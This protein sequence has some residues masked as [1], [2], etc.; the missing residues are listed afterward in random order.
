[1]KISDEGAHRIYELSKMVYHSNLSAK[2][3]I[4]F[5]LAE[6]LMAKSSAQ[7]YLNIFKCLMNGVAH[8]RA[9]NAYSTEYFLESIYDD[10]GKDFFL[11]ALQSTA[12][13]VI[14]YNSLNHGRRTSISKIIDRLTKKYELDIELLTVYPDEI[15]GE[16]FPEGMSKQVLINLFERNK[17]ARSACIEEHGLSCC[18][19][20]FNF[21][22]AYGEIGI[23]FIHVHH[24]VNISDI[25]HSYQVDPKRDLIPVCPNC[26]AMLH[27]SKP[28]HTIQ[29]LKAH[30]TNYLNGYEKLG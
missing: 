2:K 18:V 30:L 17:N 15:D 4:E 11:K 3:A 26:H 9:I 8:K 1:M 28:A 21:E 10:Y 20:N 27:K 16:T 12:L 14:Y 13:H 29:Q 5:I 6:N 7:I 24:V 25:G 19:C 22:K 23:G